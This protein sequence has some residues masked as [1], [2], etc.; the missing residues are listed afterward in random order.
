MSKHTPAPWYYGLEGKD[1][2]HIVEKDGTNIVHLATLRNSTA[3]SRM[4]ANVRLMT[5]SPE[6]L[7]ALERLLAVVSHDKQY[8]SEQA[9]F[10]HRNAVEK[11]R[12]AI[13][14]AEGA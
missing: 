10:I 14:K 7:E 2:Y 13:A 1:A 4:E 12:Q 6:L 11:A 8:V 3:S 9:P 5:T